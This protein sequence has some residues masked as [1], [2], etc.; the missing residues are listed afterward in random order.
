MI[1]VAGLA[2]ILLPLLFLYIIYALD[3]YSSGRFRT[4]A[5]CFVWGLVAFGISLAINTGIKN[6]ALE[7]WLHMGPYQALALIIVLVA[8]IV[9][10]L[11][12]SLVLVYYGRRPDF[13]YFVDGAIYGFA[14]GIGFSVLENFWYMGQTQSAGQTPVTVI[15]RS[16]STCLMHG[17]ASALVGVAIGRFRYEHGRTRIL[18]M[19]LGWGAAIGLHAAFNRVTYYWTGP[20]LLIGSVALGIGGV[21]LIAVFIRWGLAQ[22]KRWI[23]DTLGL[24]LGVTGKEKA[25]VREMHNLEDLLKP[26]K[27]RFGKEKA[28]DVESFLV[29]QAQL[30]IK[31][32][33]W[34]MA[35]DPRLKAQI[36]EQIGALRIEMEA[37]RRRVGVYC[38]T[39]VRTI[40]PPDSAALWSNLERLVAESQKRVPQFDLWG[41]LQAA[42]DARA[43][44][45]GQGNPES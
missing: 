42:A 16:F 38:M 8:P 1:F 36:Q 18:A 32:K 14:A 13:T 19:I 28:A 25:L 43:E 6:L 20:A 3:L 11:V 22:E 33:S 44:D 27:E 5:L 34:E 9:E 29:K 35:A 21:V 10:E 4:V 26:I 37:I 15:A 45:G 30:G 40:F 23:E 39:Y 7:G 12:K 24:A 41:K 31:Q 2:A 17:S